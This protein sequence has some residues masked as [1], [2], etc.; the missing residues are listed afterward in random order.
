MLGSAK[1]WLTYGQTDN[2]SPLGAKLLCLGIDGQCCGWFNP[3]QTIR[4]AHLKALLI[5]KVYGPL[6]KG[7]RPKKQRRKYAFLSG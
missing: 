3:R 4:N 1:I 7:N 6:I 5:V 2:L